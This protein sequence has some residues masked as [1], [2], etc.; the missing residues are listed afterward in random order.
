MTREFGSCQQFNQHSTHFTL[1]PCSPNDFTFRGSVQ[2]PCTVQPLRWNVKATAVA[3]YPTPNMNNDLLS[4]FRLSSLTPF[5]TI[6][7]RSAKRKGVTALRQWRV[8]AVVVAC[9]ALLMRRVAKASTAATLRCVVRRRRALFEIDARCV[10]ALVWVSVVQGMIDRPAVPGIQQQH[11]IMSAQHPEDTLIVCNR[12]CT[13]DS[14]QGAVVC[15][16]G[17]SWT[18]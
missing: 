18:N 16:R 11:K 8:V 3:T 2:V 15:D 10:T 14:M 5:S 1:M 4:M 6:S 7:W 13:M 12:H 9:T 17:E